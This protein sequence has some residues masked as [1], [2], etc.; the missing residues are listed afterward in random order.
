MKRVCL[1]SSS[2]LVLGVLAFTAAHAMDPLPRSVPTPA[3]NPSTPAKVELGKQL[4]FDPRLSA[5]GTVSCNSCHN[6]MEA[7]ED[8]RSVSVGVDGEKGARSAPTVW[9]AAFLSVQFWDGR[10][11]SLEAQ[12]KGPMVNPVEMGMPDHETVVRRIATIPGYVEEFRKV[13][14]GA[15][16]VTIDNAAMAIAAYERTLIT[17][18]SAFDRYRAGDKAALSAQALRGM[19][20]VENAGCTACHNG[21]VFAGPAMSEGQGFFMKFP[22]VPG[23]DYEKKYHL[24]EDLGRYAVT[25]LDGDRNTWR[26]PQWRNIALTAPYFHNGSVPTLDEAVRVMG[27][28]Q[29]DRDL[30]PEEVND[31]VAFLGSLTGEFPSQTMPRLPSTPQRSVVQ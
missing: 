8:D 24:T 7:G 3:T 20:L 23:S 9:N 6:V 30:K 17:P 25:K 22:T 27:K 14:G 26:V 1:I 12:A 5:T 19:K 10:A 4:F 28:T 21:P 31:A 29:L 13:F 11:P 16:P 18:K 15:S 2:V